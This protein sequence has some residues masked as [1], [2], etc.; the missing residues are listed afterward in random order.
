MCFSRSAH[1]NDSSQ[2]TRPLR[3]AAIEIDGIFL[4][5][6]PDEISLLTLANR[7]SFDAPPG[8]GLG[9]CAWRPAGTR[10]MTTM[11]MAAE[12]TAIRIAT[13]M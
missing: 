11:K 4:C 5:S 10:P 1:P 12:T 7:A 6:S 8:P 13:P 9:Y 2:M 3:A